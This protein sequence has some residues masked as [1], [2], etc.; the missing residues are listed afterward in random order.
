MT[1]SYFPFSLEE[2]KKRYQTKSNY[3]VQIRKAAQKLAAD[4]YLLARDLQSIEQLSAREWEFVM[5][6]PEG[7]VQQ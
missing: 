3:L 4:G 7:V 1:G 6:A 5:A 2:V